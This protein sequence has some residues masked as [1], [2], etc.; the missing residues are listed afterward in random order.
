MQ[1]SPLLLRITNIYFLLLGIGTAIPTLIFKYFS[2]SEILVLVLCALP[3]LARKAWMRVICG[4]L[5]AVA[6]VVI[7][8][9]LVSDFI[10]YISGKVLEHPWVYFGIGFLLALSMLFFSGVLLYFGFRHDEATEVSKPVS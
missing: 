8:F 7:F 10:D 4:V 2:I 5:G 3:I 6:G 1:K 9:A